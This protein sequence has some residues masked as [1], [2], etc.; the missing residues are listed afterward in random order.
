LKRSRN[1]I[2]QIRGAL[3][4]AGDGRAAARSLA[5][6][7]RVIPYRAGLLLD[8]AGVTKICTADTCCGLE[9]MTVSGDDV[10]GRQDEF[11]PKCA[12]IWFGPA[13][14]CV[15]SKVA[16]AAPLAR[17]RFATTAAPF[18]SDT[19]PLAPALLH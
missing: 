2:C 9:Y 16:R 11:P 8:G 14:S 7:D 17:G 19:E 12:T 10:L 15:E 18:V 1:L 3:L 6:S 5:Q 4:E 13:M